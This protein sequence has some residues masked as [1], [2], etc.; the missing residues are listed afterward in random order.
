MLDDFGLVHM[1]GRLYDPH[2]GR[3]V[4]PDPFLDGLHATQAW[5][6]Y[7]YVGNNPLSYTDPSGHFIAELTAAAVA[8]WQT[9]KAYYV[10]IHISYAAFR[11]YQAGGIGGAIQAV[12]IT[13]S[14]MAITYGVGQQFGQLQPQ[15]PWAKVG[16]ELARAATHGTVQGLTGMGAGGRFRSG[17]YAGFF[18]SATG[19][20]NEGPFGE[21][22]LLGFVVSIVVGGTTSKLGG[23]K[24]SNGARSAAMVYVLN[25]VASH[26]RDVA[27]R[28]KHELVIEVYE[29]GKE[30]KHMPPGTIGVTS[31]NEAA[32]VIRNAVAENGFIDRLYVSGHGVEGS[33][34]L[35]LSAQPQRSPSKVG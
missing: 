9:Y 28:G 13:G 11:G 20:A 23:G 29:S 18:S 4:S 6:R 21:N 14:T 30:L 27:D 33:R 26:A 10:V 25:Q 17:F 31:F 22:Q 5:D 7:A 16:V 8:I 34:S 24:F 12:A 19:H 15:T 2:L 3:F 35:T 32:E 1:N